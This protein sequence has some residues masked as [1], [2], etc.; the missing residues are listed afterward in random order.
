MREIKE[1]FTPEISDDI[2]RADI[3]DMEIKKEAI[4]I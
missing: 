3:N 1:I 4:Q 2:V